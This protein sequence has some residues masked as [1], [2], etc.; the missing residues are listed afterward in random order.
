MTV[1]EEKQLISQLRKGDEAAFE[2][3]INIYKNYVGTIIINRIGNSMTQEDV[4]EVVS[5]VFVALWKNSKK[6]NPDKGTLKAYL[7]SIS[8]YQS[9]NKL[10]DL[11][12]NEIHYESMHDKKFESNAFDEMVKSTY[13]SDREWRNNPEEVVIGLE[14]F[15]E[16][17][18]ELKSLKEL[19][20]RIFDMFYNRDMSI[21]D[22]SAE[23][24]MKCGTVKIRLHR[25]RKKLK[26]GLLRRGV[27]L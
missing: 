7:A 3:A 4:E 15:S 5:D 8:V 16:I 13:K 17:L 1:T 2:E 19:D 23:E 10:R 22:I 6:L 18:E 26:T 24:N 14:S 21:M 11:K 20:R 25:M 12:G 9:L 27:L